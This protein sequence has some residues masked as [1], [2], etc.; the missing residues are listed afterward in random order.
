MYKQQALAASIA[1]A[2]GIKSGSS[3]NGGISEA[4]STT[5]TLAAKIIGS[6]K[7]GATVPDLLSEL[8][9]M[10]RDGTAAAKK[11]DIQVLK[12]IVNSVPLDNWQ[13]LSR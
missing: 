10:E 13:Y 8:D 7:N 11:Y 5:R 1:K 2:S 3:G 6:L 4:N 12:N 9:E